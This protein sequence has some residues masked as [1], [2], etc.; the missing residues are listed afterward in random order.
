MSVKAKLILSVIIL[1]ILLAIG[2]FIG[3][4]SLSSFN[5]K[6]NELVEV[7][8]EKIINASR[9]R[10]KV[11]LLARNEKNF[12]SVNSDKTSL[13]QSRKKLTKEFEE[14][15]KTLQDLQ[16][17]RNMKKLSQIEEIFNSYIDI[18]D[19]KLIPL[20]LNNQYALATDFST[21]Q[22]RKLM[23][24]LEN[25]LAEITDTNIEKLQKRKDSTDDFYASRSLLLIITLLLSFAFAGGISFWLVTSITKSLNVVLDSVKELRLSAENVSTTSIRLSE[26]SS[27]QAASIEETTASVEEMSSTITQ[28][29]G[30]AMETNSMANTSAQDAERGKESVLETLQAMRNISKKI[31]IIEDIAYQTNILA[32]NAAI[33]AARVGK[34]GKG[35]S[36][37]AEEVRKLAER[38][39]ESAQEI[40]KLAI[41]SVELAEAAGK[42]IEEIVPSI[43]KTAQMVQSIAETSTE[44]SKGME[45]INQAMTQMDEATQENAASSEE[46]A[47]TASNLQDQANSLFDTMGKLVN[48]KNLDSGENSKKVSMKEIASKFKKQEKDDSEVAM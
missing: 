7:N 34:H 37:V 47:A 29:S 28:N 16:D 35:F 14:Q 44:Q 39:R 5:D 6:L 3:I 42:L 41:D 36:V 33:E 46:M 20:A 26:A 13:S 19:N 17:E 2:I 38:S 27:E 24:K 9:L 4:V 21:N 30:T 43:Q 11:L 12:L 40:N 10:Q 32:L 8:A 23:D 18:V 15:L 22:S 48:I 1:N 25:L 45:Q 31:K